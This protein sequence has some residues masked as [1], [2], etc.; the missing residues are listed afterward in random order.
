MMIGHFLMAID[1]MPVFYTAMVFLIIGVGGIKG[2]ISTVVGK[3]YGQGDPRRDRGFTIFYIGIN[4][5]SLLAPLIC[6]YLGEAVSWHLGFAV[7]GVGMGIG[8]LTFLFGQPLL[9]GVNLDAPARSPREAQ[10]HDPAAS[11]IEWHRIL[12]LALI[13]S[14]VVLFWAGYFQTWVSLVLWA[15][16]NTYRPLLPA[17]L[18]GK[19][20]PATWTQTF[21]AAFIIVLA[22]VVSALWGAL[23]RRG[24]EPSATTK[25]VLGLAFLGLCYV[26]MVVA[27]RVTGG[28]DASLFWLV[29][30][31][32][33]MTLGELALSP[34]GL[35]LVTKLAPPRIGGLLMG[36]WFWTLFLG[37]KLGGWVGG[38][39]ERVS[40]AAFFGGW[41]VASL[42]AAGVFLLILPTIKRL[43]HGA[44]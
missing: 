28:H 42:V 35:S 25:M 5:G 11:E 14:F 8:L 3:L 34:V 13:F 37:F 30:C 33:F 19:Q 17:W 15:D 38:F 22:P 2:N 4:I 18:G 39:W 24:R 6:G 7:A 20:F 36:V 32:F 21:N 23:G 26:V 29:G 40:H 41:T 16:A 1:R 9:R 44:D 31:F 43:A 12:V 27:A 10:P